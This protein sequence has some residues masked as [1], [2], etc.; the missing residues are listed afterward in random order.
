M[1]KKETS[2][3]DRSA[4]VAVTVF[5]LIIVA[6]AV[7]AYFFPAAASHLTPYIA[8]GLGFIMFTMGLTLRVEDFKRV[9]E[10]PLAILIGVA[11]QYVIMPIV[12]IAVVKVLNLPVGLAIGFIL[13]G[14]APGGTA[15]NVVAYLAKADVALSVT[16][17]TVSTLLAPIFT[18]LLVQ[19]LAGTLT[20]I[21]GLA[22]AISILKTVV[23]PVVGGVVL[24]L[25]LPAVIDKILPV[26]P[27]VSTLGISAVVAALIPGSAQAIA[28][29]M[30]VVL[31]AVIVHN[32]AGLLI[33]YWAARASG[34][35]R[36]RRAQ[37]A[38]RWVC[39]T[40]ASPPR[41]VRRT[42]PPPPR[43]PCR[44]SSS[45][46]GTTSPARWSHCT[47]AAAPAQKPL[48][49]HPGS[50]GSDQRRSFDLGHACRV[51]VISHDDDRAARP[52]GHQ[53][54]DSVGDR[55]LDEHARLADRASR[56]HALH[57]GQFLGDH[58][59]VRLRHD[60]GCAVRHA[61]GQLSVPGEGEGVEVEG[62]DLA[63]RLNLR[64]GG[65]DDAPVSAYS[66]PRPRDYPAQRPGE[67]LPVQRQVE[68]ELVAGFEAALVGE[69]VGDLRDVIGQHLARQL[70]PPVGVVPGQGGGGAAR[71]E[72]L[73]ERGGHDWLPK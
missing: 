26:L 29:A 50:S 36:A 3:E 53:R 67:R 19:W 44:A 45:R 15:S 11:A 8:P 48:C 62:H 64:V 14:A 6:G 72:R 46:C 69:V 68:G 66:D 73:I 28:T 20:D 65:H 31:V 52:R 71:E 55:G 56:A 18:P 27:W 7:W 43:L 13:L 22:M 37:S 59:R 5:P 9:A 17:T 35:R 54:R 42:S 25:L 1:T 70:D 40:P 60:L 61:V 24:R 21:D 38:S 4:L 30:G 49:A 12:A 33:G 23:I 47:S 16:L 51:A 32:L 10:R 63:A 2:A 57:I 58:E 34:S 41:W 39:K